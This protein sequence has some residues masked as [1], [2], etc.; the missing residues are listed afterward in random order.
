MQFPCNVFEISAAVGFSARGGRALVANHPFGGVARV[1]Q[2]R[3][4]LQSLS[5]G[6]A[7]GAELRAKLEN[8]DDAVLADVVLNTILRDTGIHIVIPAMM[9]LKHIQL[10]VGAVRE[11]RFTSTEL[12]QIREALAAAQ[13]AGPAPK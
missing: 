12:A 3:E 1:Q 7:L 5:S 13:N 8:A 11:S 4:V 9:K 10:N 2:C 6:S